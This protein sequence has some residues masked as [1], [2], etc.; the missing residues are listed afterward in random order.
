MRDHS[1]YPEGAA[2]IQPL[3]GCDPLQRPAPGPVPASLRLV[4]TAAPQ[5]ALPKQRVPDLPLVHG[6][7][8]HTPLWGTRVSVGWCR[9]FVYGQVERSGLVAR[10][11]ISGM[12]ANAL[13]V[14][15]LSD[16]QH[17]Q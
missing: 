14:T 7:T 2:A 13:A 1:P 12:A 17:A 8:V 3:G 16:N 6:S 11:G 10:A 15:L 9:L 4:I 5:A